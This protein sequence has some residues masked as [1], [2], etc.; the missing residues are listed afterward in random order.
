MTEEERL[1][2]ARRRTA[3]YRERLKARAEAH[4]AGDHSQ[5]RANQCEDAGAAVDLDAEGLNEPDGDAGEGVT[6]DVTDT[7]KN[8]VSHRP[9]PAGLGERGRL[10]WDEMSSLRLGPM[11]VYL[12]ERA[13]RKADRLARM[14]EQLAGREWLD[15]V[16]VPNTD[17]AVVQVVV[18]KL[19]GEV[20][21][22]EIA[23]KL[24]VAELRHAGRTATP[25]T[26]A[27]PPSVEGDEGGGSGGK[28]RGLA[29]I[30]GGLDTTG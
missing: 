14:D 9:S 20:R 27:V 10:L 30:R 22:T 15:L 8:P 21:Q 2:A 12:L 17:G 23:L 13:C 16:E 4:D 7:P 24:D 28:R 5:C 19:L 3:R 1:E 18:D 29:A 26:G 11:H 6:R 25:A